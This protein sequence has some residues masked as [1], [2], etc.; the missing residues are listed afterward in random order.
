[1]LS[2]QALHFVEEGENDG[3]VSVR[4]RL[5]VDATDVYVTVQAYK[6]KMYVNIREHF[7]SSKF[8]RLLPTKRGVVLSKDQWA[9]LCG[10]AQKVQRL[11]F[12]N[13]E[14]ENLQQ[15][16]QVYKAD[17]FAI[18]V[19]LFGRKV[20]LRTTKMVKGDNNN[21]KGTTIEMSMK[22]FHAIYAGRNSIDE[23]IEQGEKAIGLAAAVKP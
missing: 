9:I 22:E 14:L 20:E 21:N 10:S 23:A 12:E 19:A 16:V 3:Q 5:P 7:L 2:T 11:S 4:A 1:M 15:D 18:T 6:G 17:N 13:E 8:N